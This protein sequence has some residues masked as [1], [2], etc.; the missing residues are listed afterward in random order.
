MTPH[1][2]LHLL[3]NLELLLKTINDVG[4]SNVIQLIIDNVANCKGEGKIIERVHPHIFWSGCLVHILN[5]SMHDIVKHKGCGWI[6]DLYKRGK[7]PIKFVTR[8]TRVNY[9]Y[10]THSAN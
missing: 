3:N 6:N 9:F 7:K 5:I 10:G 8:H 1:Q 4:P 2:S